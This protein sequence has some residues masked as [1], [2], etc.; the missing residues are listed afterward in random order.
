MIG[1]LEWSLYQAYGQT[2]GGVFAKPSTGEV[3]S[4]INSNPFDRY[5]D[6]AFLKRKVSLLQYPDRTVLE[7]KYGL[8][9]ESLLSLASVV[10]QQFSLTLDVAKAVILC[11]LEHHSRPKVQT[12]ADKLNMSKRN[13]FRWLR[14]MYLFLDK[15]KDSAL[16]RLCN[17][18][19]I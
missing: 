9:P 3:K 14:K 4:T 17:L 13:T 19:A 8:I 5:V 6:A 1:R 15:I 18:V 10:Q 11:W 16:D 7:A 12:I 2:Q